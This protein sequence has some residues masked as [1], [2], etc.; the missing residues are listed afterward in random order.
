MLT[1]LLASQQNEYSAVAAGF[2]LGVLFCLIVGYCIEPKRRVFRHKKGNVYTFV[3]EG[4]HSESLEELVVYKGN[5]GDIWVR[6]KAM[7]FDG[8]FTE[9]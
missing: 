7:F 4:R 5:S 8:R 2:T 6:P 1:L 3:G 9:L